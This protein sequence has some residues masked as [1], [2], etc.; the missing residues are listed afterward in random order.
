MTILLMKNINLTFLFFIF[1]FTI[2]LSISAQKKPENPYRSSHL[3]EEAMAL[4][5]SGFAPLGY[6]GGKLGVD[7]PIKII[8]KRGF[9][10]FHAGRDFRE[11]YATIEA[12]FMHRVGAYENMGLS[13]EL[14]YRRVE[15][16]NGWFWQVSPIGVGGNYVM[17]PNFSEVA[18]PS[19][20]TMAHPLLARKW[21][22][23]PSVSLG[24][25]RDFA[26]SK[27]RRSGLPL[28]IYSKIG[29]GSMLPYKT[30]GYLVPTAELGFGYRFSSLAIATRQVRRS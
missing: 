19:S 22:V 28:V 20:G 21:Y 6:L 27:G 12:V 24:F 23:T 18:A 15:G 10:G 14:T 11:W 2:P 17:P 3:G 4:H 30:F 26:L 8:E 7:L 9:K 25:G 13:A 16:M 5:I 1:F 29:I